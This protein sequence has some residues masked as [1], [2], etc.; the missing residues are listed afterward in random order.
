MVLGRKN[1]RA[2]FKRSGAD[3]LAIA[4]L[5]AVVVLAS[6]LSGCTKKAGADAPPPVH[7]SL[8]NYA[9]ATTATAPVEISGTGSISAWQEAPVGAEVGGLTAVALLVDE[10]QSVTQGQPLLK[11]DDVL[12]RA[13]V[14]QAQ[15]LE[16]QNEKAYNRSK[17]L[18]SQGY[19][20]QAG[21]ETAEASYLTSEAA[22]QTAQTQ[23]SLATVRAPV[24]GIITERKAVLGQIVTSGAELFKIVRDGR[25][26]LNMEVVESD[27]HAIQP[28]MAATVT[29]DSI[30]PVAGSVRIVTSM[31][32]PTTRLG[33]ARISV[34][35]SS[36]LRPGMFATGKVNAG[37]QQVLMIPQKAVVYNQNAPSVYVIDA[38]NKVSLHRVVTGDLQGDNVIVKSGLQ[39]GD[40]VATTGAGFLNEGDTVKLAQQ[41]AAAGG[42][43]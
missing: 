3:C 8:V 29:S 27:L 23:L 36:G 31:V 14:K 7:A 43:H 6:S 10:G 24:S 19:L 4:G 5:A 2:I 26:E 9:V 25:V 17:Q 34:P 38:S 28:G 16:T 42:E 20:A 15:A 32:D 11:M 33:V 35:W 39:A 18:F 22:L 41:V 21:L 37:D 13:Q 1:A 12:L 40:K 30:G